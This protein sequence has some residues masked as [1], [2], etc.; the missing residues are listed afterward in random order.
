MTAINDAHCHFFS[1]SFLER[2]AAEADIASEDPARSV[3]EQAGWDPPLGAA[4]LADRWVQELDRY[5]VGRAGLIASL[6]GD[7]GSVAEAVSRHPGRFV[8]YFMANP[9]TEQSL[10]RIEKVLSRQGMRVVCLFPSMHHYSLR[11]PQVLELFQLLQDHPGTAVFVHCGVLSVGIRQKLGLKSRFDL[12]FA[13]PLHLNR[14]AAECPRV[15][16]IIP[17][18]GAGHFREAL[19]VA[20]VCPNV[21]LDT[22]SSNRWIRYHPG[23]TLEKVFEQALDVIGPDRLLFGTDSSFFPRGWQQQIY[24]TQRQA[25]DQIGCAAAVQEKILHGN[26]ERL[27]P[28]EP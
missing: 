18:F 24:E 22:S 23:L 4:E 15:P 1:R 26:F 19:M 13:N 8:G 3:T 28:L 10:A 9:T 21:Y 6:P 14:A 20:S 7:E 17:H 25:L 11:E 12:Y 5:G 2:L 16:V 27:F